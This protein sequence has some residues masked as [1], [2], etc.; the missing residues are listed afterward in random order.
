MEQKIK[1]LTFFQKKV[2][3]CKIWHFWL[4]WQPRVRFTYNY[5]IFLHAWILEKITLNL[6]PH[7]YH[8]KQI[9]ISQNTPP[10]FH[11]S[12]Y[13]CTPVSR[14]A[15]SQ[16]LHDVLLSLSKSCTKTVSTSNIHIFSPHTCPR[17]LKN[18]IKLISCTY[19]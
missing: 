10:L 16:N 14:Q 19:F 2:K 18:K 8:L 15:D 5:P 4:P 3:I 6:I 7:T 11:F 12:L 1:I 17:D 13:G 9:W